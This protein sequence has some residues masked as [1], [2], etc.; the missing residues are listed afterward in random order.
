MASGVLLVV[1]REHADDTVERR[2]EQQRLTRLGCHVEQAA[3]FGKES[4]VGHA[5]GFVDD[6]D[7]D[8]VERECALLDEIGEP[9]RARDEHVDAAVELAALRLVADAAVDDADPARDRS[10][11]RFEL[12]T[13]LGGELT[14]RR[15]DRARSACASGRG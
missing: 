2:R 15:E 10:G 5:V 1:A 7:F 4:H 3:D 8:R 14:R 13:D 9:A 6:D 12:T 11:Q